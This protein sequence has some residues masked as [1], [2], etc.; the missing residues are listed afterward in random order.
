MPVD[1][2]KGPIDPQYSDYQN[3]LSN[4]Q[5]NI[6]KPHARDHA[7]HMFLKF[8]AEAAAVRRWMRDLAQRY[9]TSAQLRSIGNP[10][11]GLLDAAFGYRSNTD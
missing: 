6:L 4:L 8:K 7:V 9:V 10:F 5:G 2:S 11:H 3:M 1:L